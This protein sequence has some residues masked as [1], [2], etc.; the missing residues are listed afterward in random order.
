MGEKCI[1]FFGQSS[2]FIYR[3]RKKKL[4]TRRSIKCVFIVKRVI[5]AVKEGMA[6]STGFES[7]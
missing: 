5:I 2:D 4:E 7:E 3:E 1:Y 6:T